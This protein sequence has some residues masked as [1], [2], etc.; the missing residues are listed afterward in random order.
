QLRH[1]IE[2]LERR[3]RAAATRREKDAMYDLAAIRV[4]LMPQGVRQERRLNYVPLFARYGDLLITQL[5]AGAAQHAG[6]L[7]SGK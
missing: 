6:A 7:I 1:R 2:R 5:N 4:A 3:I